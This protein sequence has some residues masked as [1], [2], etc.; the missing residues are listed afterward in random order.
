V[1]EVAQAIEA[2]GTELQDRAEVF[3][4]ASSLV[5]VVAD[6]AGGISGGAK[7]ATY[8]IDKIK[9]AVNSGAFVPENAANFLSALD[10]E[11]AAAG[12]FGETTCV[13]AV[14]DK[15][16]LI[17]ASVGDSAAW[18]IDGLEPHDLTAAQ[19]RK[20][21][22]GSGRAIPIPFTRDKTAGTLLVASDGLLKYASRERI[23]V[24]TAMPNLDEAAKKLIEL[25]RYPSGALPDDVSVILAR[26]R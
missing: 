3:Y 7:A 21:L 1:F 6:G 8:V 23:A 22:L 26:K 18:I 12:T 2:G 24:I 13:L 9:E 16:K 4:S 20:P 17:G 14:F 5:A 15:G 25:V 10:H 19:I 11:M